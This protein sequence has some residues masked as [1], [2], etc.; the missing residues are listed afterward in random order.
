MLILYSYSLE[1]YP[2]TTQQYV[3]YKCQLPI[4]DTTIILS[5]FYCNILTYPNIY[6]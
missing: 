1:T 4:K 5:Y 2:K 3:I 6:S